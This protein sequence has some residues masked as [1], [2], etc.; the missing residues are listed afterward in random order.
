V[1]AV[2]EEIR[3]RSSEKE[4]ILV[5]AL[6]QLCVRISSL[7]Q[8]IADSLKTYNDTEK[9]SGTTNR[10]GKGGDVDSDS[11]AG[12]AREAAKAIDAIERE[13]QQQLRNVSTSL[14]AVSFIFLYCSKQNVYCCFAVAFITLL[15]LLLVWM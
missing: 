15:L 8:K 2:E 9:I 11:G 10:K 7:E 4:E 3:K 12:S 6:P 5:A 13:K 14:T 1:K